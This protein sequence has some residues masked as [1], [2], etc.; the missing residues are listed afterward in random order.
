MM[1]PVVKTY[2]FGVDQYGVY[3]KGIYFKMHWSEKE[4]Y[5]RFLLARMH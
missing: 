4:S 2:N 3:E 1:P 5:A